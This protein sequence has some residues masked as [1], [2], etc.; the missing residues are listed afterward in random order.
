MN[1]TDSHTK[2]PQP[3]YRFTNQPLLGWNLLVLVL[4]TLTTGESQADNVFLANI[5][6]I[7][8]L[9]S[10]ALGLCAHHCKLPKVQRSQDKHPPGPGNHFLG[11]DIRTHQGFFMQAGREGLPPFYRP[12]FSAPTQMQ[13]YLPPIQ[14]VT[15]ISHK[16]CQ[17]LWPLIELE[18]CLSTAKKKRLLGVNITTKTE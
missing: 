16:M 3:A 6:S 12:L 15:Q 5:P 1:T 14:V 17:L 4:Q 13:V 2:H 11:L 18:S 8:R 9:W 7:K 10:T